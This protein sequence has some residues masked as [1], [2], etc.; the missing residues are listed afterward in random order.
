MKPRRKL[1]PDKLAAIQLLQKLH[2]P[3][4]KN[5]FRYQIGLSARAVFADLEPQHREALD[6]RYVQGKTVR[7]IAQLTGAQLHDIYKNLNQG[8]ADF[9]WRLKEL[10]VF[11]KLEWQ[12]I[13]TR[14][15]TSVEFKCAE[16]EEVL[17]DR[18]KTSMDV[19]CP[20]C[21]CNMRLKREKNGAVAV[22]MLQPAR[23]FRPYAP[24]TRWECFEFLGVP[25]NAPFEIIQRAYRARANEFHPDRFFGAP[26]YAQRVAEEF[27]KMLNGARETIQS[28]AP[29]VI[30]HAAHQ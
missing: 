11:M 23:V 10:G 4:R 21:G 30:Q 16:C 3:G 29:E 20:L 28:N 7:K 8:L 24:L 5:S 17:V 18:M 2:A 27:M 13:G 14:R 12:A 19:D 26:R 25:P 22:E 9:T 15:P 6:L 1:S